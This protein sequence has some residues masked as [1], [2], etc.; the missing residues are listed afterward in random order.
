MLMYR[1]SLD[2]NPTLKPLCGI[3]SDLQ[4][5]TPQEFG[6][7]EIPGD[8]AFGQAHHFQGPDSTD[9]RGGCPTL[10]TLANHGFL[11]RK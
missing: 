5:P 9:V 6:L 11:P 8:D 1:T 7:K 3:L 2:G 4:L 10:N